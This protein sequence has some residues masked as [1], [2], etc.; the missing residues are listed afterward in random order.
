M[1][2]LFEKRLEGLFVV[3]LC[4]QWCSVRVHR[5]APWEYSVGIPFSLLFWSCNV[6]LPWRVYYLYWEGSLAVLSTSLSSSGT[7]QSLVC[8]AT[9]I[10]NIFRS[11]NSMLVIAT[12]TQHY[13]KSLIYSLASFY[14]RAFTTS[15]SYVLELVLITSHSICSLP[16][17]FLSPF[18]FLLLQ[19]S[20]YFYVIFKRAHRMA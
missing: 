20:F 7:F 9:K 6:S 12:F 5:C 13:W 2:F 19:V 8:S 17:F 11:L 15:D 10:S 18:S 14:P 4:G 3:L 1:E 16:S